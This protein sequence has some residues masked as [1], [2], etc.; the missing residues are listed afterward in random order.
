MKLTCK[1]NRTTKKVVHV[2]PEQQLNVLLTL[3]NIGD[4]RAKFVYKGFTYGLATIF[5]FK[6]IGLTTDTNLNIVTPARAGNT[7]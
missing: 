4:K 5:T 7:Q 6:E 2:Q 3:L 1:I